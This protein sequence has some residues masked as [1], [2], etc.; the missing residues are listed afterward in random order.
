MSNQKK[1]VRKTIEIFIK[2]TFYV[3]LR[4]I[5]SYITLSASKLKNLFKCL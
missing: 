3:N 1:N 5:G 4:N 2:T